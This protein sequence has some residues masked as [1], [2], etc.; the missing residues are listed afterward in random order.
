MSDSHSASMSQAAALPLDHPSHIHGESHA[1]VGH[2]AHQFE[3]AAQQKEAV[4]LGMWSFLA[5]EIMFFGGAFLAYFIYRTSYHEAFAAASLKENIW[6]GF[7]NTGVLLCSSLTM[8]LAVHS[9][10]EGKSSG[11]KFWV[12]MTILFAFIF[13]GVKAYEYT[14]LF[15]EHLVPGKN[16]DIHR[17]M[18]PPADGSAQ[19]I[20]HANYIRRGAQIFFS[21][22]FAATG[23]HATHMFVGIGIMIW[24]IVKASRGGFTRDYYNPVEITGLYWHFVDIVWIFLYPLLYLVDRTGIHH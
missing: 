18:F 6:V 2:V 1:H 3:D 11:I 16:F 23:L 4:T 8:A 17:E 13:L 21:F 9:A 15:H 22:Y 24:L 12:S 20:E 14:H 19:A 10:H 5:T 7:A